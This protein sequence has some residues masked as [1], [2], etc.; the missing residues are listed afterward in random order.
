MVLL[1]LLTETQVRLRNG[2]GFLHPEKH[3][4]CHS[5]IA[6]ERACVLARN[7]SYL[8][9]ACSARICARLDFGVHTPHRGLDIDDKMW[10]FTSL[11]DLKSNSAKLSA[12]LA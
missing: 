6:I 5:Y 12:F 1:H 9:L 10:H 3:E 11:D 7:D 8:E 4:L 2:Q